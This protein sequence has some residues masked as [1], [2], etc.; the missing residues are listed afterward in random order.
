MKCYSWSF[1]GQKSRKCSL[2]GD[3]VQ[4]MDLPNTCVAVH[5]TVGGAF[6]LVCIVCIFLVIFVNRRGTNQV[7]VTVGEVY[8]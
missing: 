7:K 2:E 8:M 3:S 4:W 1:I 6:V 5:A